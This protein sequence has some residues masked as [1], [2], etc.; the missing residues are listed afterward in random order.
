MSDKLEA[1]LDSGNLEDIDNIL[2]KLDAGESEEDVL[3]AI[4]SGD[5]GEVEE[6]PADP[7]PSQEAEPAAAVEEPPKVEDPPAAPV[8]EAAPEVETPEEPVVLAKDGKNQIP[9]SV[10]E[11]ERH[12]A[13]QLKATL[14]ELERRNTLLESQL[15]AADIKPKDLPERVRFTP[16]QLSDFESY[17]EIGEAVAILAQQ[18]EM[19]QERLA[20]QSYTA[21]VVTQSEA[22]NPLAANPDTNRWASDDAQWGMVESVNAMLDTNPE[23]QSKSLEERIP[24]IVRRTKVALGERSDDTI[25][26]EADAAI[27]AAEE[28]S[29][30]TSLTDVG[31]A[32][33]G[34]EKSIQEQLE[35]G[36]FADAEAYLAAATKNGRSVDDVLSSLLK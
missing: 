10:L 12:N 24:E 5:T 22:V 3:A 2:T 6:P 16:E 34:Q 20:S 26:A 27:A 23:W 35:E 17:G 36:D 32:V 15:T 18:N 7:T 30:P 14:D 28:R 8:V 1:M 11:Q 31:G 29:A 25:N 33:L 21:P 9:Y 13:A 19:L 4:E